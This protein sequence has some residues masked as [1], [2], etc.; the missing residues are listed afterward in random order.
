VLGVDG[1]SPF[2]LAVP[3]PLVVLALVIGKDPFIVEEA[4][5]VSVVLLA[6]RSLCVE[7]V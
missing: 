4:M 1:T 6:G 3:F 2:I 7:L 5:G